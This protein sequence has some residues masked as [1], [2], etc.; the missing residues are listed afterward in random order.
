MFEILK[1]LYCLIIFSGSA[2]CVANLSGF[3]IGS[4]PAWVYWLGILLGGSWGVIFPIVYDIKPDE[5]KVV[6]G[7]ERF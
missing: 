2:I 1:Y 5:D 6:F 3:D 4:F 7:K